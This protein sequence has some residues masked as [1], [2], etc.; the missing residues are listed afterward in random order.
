MLIMGGQAES[1]AQA[2]TVLREQLASGAA[3]QKFSDM[4][5]AQGGDRSVLEN[6]KGL[7]QASHVLEVRAETGG[8][9]VD[10]D[11]EAFGRAV[12][13]LGG[14]RR[15]S[16]DPVDHAV[17]ISELVSIGESVENNG[18]LYLLHFNDPAKAEEAGSLL[19]TAI[20]LSN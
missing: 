12:L 16:D 7:P 20:Q 5:E 14:G 13:V 18:L 2:L 17:G 8:S 9:V 10:V 11:A 4:L 1:E 6:G 15:K 19:S 3:L